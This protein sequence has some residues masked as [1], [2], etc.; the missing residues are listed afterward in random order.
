MQSEYF[1]F[2]GRYFTCI[3]GRV[4]YVVYY[5]FRNVFYVFKTRYFTCTTLQIGISQFG[6]EQ[7]LRSLAYSIQRFLVQVFSYCYGKFIPEFITNSSLPLIAKT[8]RGAINKRY[9]TAAIGRCTR[10]RRFAESRRE[11]HKSSQLLPMVLRGVGG[12]VRCAGARNPVLFPEWEVT[13]NHADWSSYWRTSYPWKP[14]DLMQ[15]ITLAYIFSKRNIQTLTYA[16]C[17]ATRWGEASK[18]NK[19]GY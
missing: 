8:A 16:R 3:L 4:L 11:W 19:T 7:P 14:T 5:T 2:Q 1:R 10:R 15:A 18:K 6:C 17:T 13:V 9:L 12:R